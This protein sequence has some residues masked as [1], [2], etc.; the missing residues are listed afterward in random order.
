MLA[1]LTLPP[2]IASTPLSLLCLS[3]WVWQGAAQSLRSFA[4]QLLAVT[5]HCI[6][7][8]V[9]YIHAG[10]LIFVFNFL[11]LQ[12]RCACPF[13]AAVPR[14]Y[15]SASIVC[16]G[17]RRHALHPVFRCRDGTKYW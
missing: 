7:A 5:M 9:T 10:I 6:L 15:N 16:S 11:N 1:R 17:Y 13:H 4:T 3:V 14:A 2:T 12:W 8:I